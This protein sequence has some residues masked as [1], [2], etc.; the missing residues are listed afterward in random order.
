MMQNY[1]LSRLALSI[2]IGFFLFFIFN[3][4][5][6][7]IEKVVPQPSGSGKALVFNALKLPKVKE[8]MSRQGV[9]S[10]ALSSTDIENWTLLKGFSPNEANPGHL[11][12][13]KLGD[14]T[15]IGGLFFECD[16]GAKN[17]K[18]L[19]MASFGFLQ[20][21]WGSEAA[22][23][24][25]LYLKD[26][27]TRIPAHVMILDHPTGGPFL[28]NNGH[29]SIGSYDD[30]RMWI[31]AAQYLSQEYILSGI[32]LLG[33]SMSGQTV[34]HALIEDWRLGLGLF[35]SGI[36]VSIAPDFRHAPGIQLARLD[37]PPGVEN[38]WVRAL[39]P[40]PYETLTDIIQSRVIWMFI[41]NQFIPNHN[42]IY[43]TGNPLELQPDH[44]AIFLRKQ[45]ENRIAFLRKQYQGLAAWNHHDFSLTNLDDYMQTTRIARVIHR[46]QTPLVMLSAYDDPAVPYTQFQEVEKAAGNNPWVICYETK[47]GGHFAY[48]IVYGKAYL[49]RIIRLMMD[50]EILQT[51]NSDN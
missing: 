41:E 8:T 40:L 11:F 19:I 6:T 26:P 33:V 3:C 27:T 39:A 44:V 48:D 7:R 22:K 28:A 34:V 5:A 35:D 2:A 45:C 42:R 32:H 24:Y 30:A 17:P 23:F 31:A 46:V 47:R 18:P 21:R 37:T 29:L 12:R 1:K 13:L 14:G 9:I 50:P 38:P 51:W 49:D 43:K 16:S 20:D 15:K 10:T 25:E 36:A 4:G